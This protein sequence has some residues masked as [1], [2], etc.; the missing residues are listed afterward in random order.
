MEKYNKDY[1]K[2]DFWPCQSIG[3]YAWLPHSQKDKKVKNNK[4]PHQNH[5]KIAMY[6]VL[7][8]KKLKEKCSS[9]L[10]GGVKTTARATR[11]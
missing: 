5:Q 6:G 10:I 1:I 9:R 2:I 7:T 11:Q 3:R 4:K 8:T